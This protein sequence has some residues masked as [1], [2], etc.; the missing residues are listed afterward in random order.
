[1]EED[2]QYQE[3]GPCCNQNL[4]IRDALDGIEKQGCGCS[5]RLKLRS[6]SSECPA[7]K[8]LA[9]TTEQEEEMINKQIESKP[10]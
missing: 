4:H 2:V 7:H 5:L 10:E 9:L 8:W 3:P 6:L 1:M